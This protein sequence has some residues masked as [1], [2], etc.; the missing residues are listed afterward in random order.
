MFIIRTNMQHII[1][2]YSFLK[3][4]THCYLTMPWTRRALGLWSRVISCC[5][6]GACGLT[7]DMCDPPRF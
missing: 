4:W 5:E 2:M 7:C 1:R 6:I 3:V